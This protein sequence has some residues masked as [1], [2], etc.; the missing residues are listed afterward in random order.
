MVQRTNTAWSVNRI[1]ALTLGIVFTLI[2]LIGFLIPDEAGTN[3]KAIFGLFDVDT[4]HSLVHL[5][6]GVLGIAAAFTGYSR[7]YNRAFGVIYIILG[8]LGLIPALY[9]PAGSFGHDNGLFLG[10]MHINA[11]DHVLHLLTGLAAAVVGFGMRETDP[12]ARRATL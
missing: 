9:F 5:L 10:L 1:L 3:V 8:L 6:F 11:G 2:A 12:V 7:T 4:V